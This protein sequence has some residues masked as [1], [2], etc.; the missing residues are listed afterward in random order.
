MKP[1]NTICSGTAHL[2][3]IAQVERHAC[4][5]S[6]ALLANIGV[7]PAYTLSSI[8][9][10]PYPLSCLY[11]ILYTLCLTTQAEC[12]GMPAEAPYARQS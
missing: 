11:P 1:H 7:Q 8:L 10:A 12:I 9:P 3:S 5:H 2:T 4:L 6:T